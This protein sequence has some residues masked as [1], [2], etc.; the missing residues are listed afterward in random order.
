[1]SAFS[2]PCGVRSVN[3]VEETVDI[4]PGQNQAPQDAVATSNANRYAVIPAGEP[5]NYVKFTGSVLAGVGAGVLTFHVLLNG[6]S[7]GSQEIANNSTDPL[8]IEVN[9]PMYADDKVKVTCAVPGAAITTGAAVTGALQFGY[10][11]NNT[12]VPFK[13]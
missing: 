4:I 3:D 12:L 5:F 7:L 8:L 13:A 2:M 6:V 10:K 1:M 11:A 9:H